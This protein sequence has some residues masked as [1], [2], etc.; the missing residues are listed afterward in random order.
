MTHA[1]GIVFRLFE[2][3]PR[4]LVVNAK[5]NSG[6]FV[7]PKGRIEPG[8]SPEATALREIQEEAGVRAQ[9]LYHLGTSEFNDGRGIISVTFYLCR[10][11]A[12]APSAEKRAVQW[13]DFEEALA[14]LTFSDA[15]GLL[16][17]AHVLVNERFHE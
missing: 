8:E 15:R 11:L 14:L 16:Q 4:Y 10:F 2:G 12:D 13:C 3:Q 5:R 17:L 1:G 6:H 7:F 9:A